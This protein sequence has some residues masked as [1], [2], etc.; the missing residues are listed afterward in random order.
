MPTIEENASYW[1]DPRSW[2]RSGDNWSETWG[3]SSAQWWWT[4]LPR[5]HMFVPTGTILEIAPGF[6]RWTNFLKDLCKKL[7]VV[8]LVEECIETC[9]RRFAASDNISYYVN[10]GKSL[11]MVR[12]GSVDFVFSFDSLVHADEDVVRA[13]LSELRF[14]MKRNGAAFIHHSNLGRYDDK[15]SLTV[16]RAARRVLNSK[17]SWLSVLER[18]GIVE[19][20]GMRAKG[21]TSEKF[22]SFAEEAGLSCISQEEI[23]WN[24]G[25]LIDCISIVTPK[26]SAW[27]QPRRVIENKRWLNEAENARVLSGLYADQGGDAKAIRQ[28]TK[29]AEL[30]ELGIEPLSD[31]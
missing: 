9:K 11:P 13:Y 26:G 15:L 22:A 31:R 16:R 8:D 23:N 10:D 2:A 24:G 25:W 19:P 20:L 27:E 21:M 14:K 6:G 28:P 12:D 4:I 29:K 7:T 5:I 3:G 1:K 30:T 17:V 18:P